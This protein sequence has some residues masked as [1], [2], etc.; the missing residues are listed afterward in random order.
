MSSYG[1]PCFPLYCAL[2]RTVAGGSDL[3]SF[4]EVPR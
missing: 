2:A 1:I 4:T 3:M